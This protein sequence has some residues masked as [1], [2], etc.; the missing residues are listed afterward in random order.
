MQLLINLYTGR[1][2]TERISIQKLGDVGISNSLIGLISLRANGQCPPPGRLGGSESMAGESE[3][4]H[5][6]VVTKGK[7]S[8]CLLFLNVLCCHRVCI[9]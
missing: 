5:F 7:S 3:N 2:A 8:K 6:V 1:T 9:C 4:S